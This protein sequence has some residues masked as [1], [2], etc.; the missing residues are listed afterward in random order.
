MKIPKRPMNIAGQ[1]GA[2]SPQPNRMKGMN[3]TNPLERVMQRLQGRTQGRAISGI[4]FDTK[5]L[6]NG[7]RYG[8]S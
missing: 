6:M 5:S 1:M 3:A 8:S 7:G 4:K 2:A